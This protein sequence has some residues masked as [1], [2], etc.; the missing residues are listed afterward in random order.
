MEGNDVKCLITG[1]SGYIGSMLTLGLLSEGHCVIVL[2]HFNHRQ[3]SL[4]SC[5]SDPNFEAVRGDARD[6]G[7]MKALLQQVDVVIPL[8]A[9]VGAPACQADPTAAVSTNRDAISLLCKFASK[10]QRVIIP[11]TN[12]G[13]G[14][15]EPGVECTEE[16]P[17]RPIT[18]YGKTKVEA[19]AIALQRE[20]T[21][22]LRLAT[23]FGMSP[24]MRFG[25]PRQ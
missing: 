21:I 24:R 11:I 22:S 15:G 20:N 16:L 7:L 6:I 3:N 9:I 8:A 13:Y 12:S 10:D 23:V 4:A 17:L 25:S 19:E 5:C 18:L 2:D 1:G 14:I